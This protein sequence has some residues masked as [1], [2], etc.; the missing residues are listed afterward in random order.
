MARIDITV[1]V[2]D[3]RSQCI[4][5][6]HQNGQAQGNISFD[7]PSLDAFIRQ[8]AQC[9]QNLSEQVVP[10]LEPVARIDFERYPAW[11]VP[12]R[13]PGLQGEAMLVL[14][15]SGLGWIAFLLEPERALT[16]AHA[17]TGKVLR[18]P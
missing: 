11:Q 5:R 9:R 13:H 16:I 3:D 15:H 6:F 14:R 12:A 17:L 10:E 2:T 8:L 7:A 1:G 18:K 4:L